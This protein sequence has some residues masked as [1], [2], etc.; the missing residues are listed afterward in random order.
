MILAAILAGSGAAVFAWIVNRQTLKLFGPTVIIYIVPLVEELAKTGLAVLFNSSLVL[1]HGIFGL[2]EG[3]YDFFYS[4]QTGITAGFISLAGHAFYGLVTAWA[5]SRF[6]QI[7]PGIL[8]GF[9]V[10]TLWNMLVM[11]YVVR[12]KFK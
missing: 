9:L 11:K 4:R 1:A 3:V 7:A 8:A 5:I 10:H 6:G 12:P 2:I